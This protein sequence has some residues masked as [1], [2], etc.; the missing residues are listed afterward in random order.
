M[1]APRGVLAISAA[2]VR[3]A[4]V[5][6]CGRRRCQNSRRL[7]LSGMQRLVAAAALLRPINAAAPADSTR[8]FPSQSIP[9]VDDVV[10]A[11][12]ALG[13]PVAR[14]DE[15]FLSV[16]MDGHVWDGGDTMGF[17]KPGSKLTRVLAGALAPA[18][19]RFGGDSHSHLTYNMTESALPPLPPLPPPAYQ[20]P[21]P[22]TSMSKQQWTEINEFCAA[23]GWT[24]VFAL[25]ALLRVA[26]GSQSGRW[27]DGPTSAAA[28]LLA[29]TYA[30]QSWAPVVW[31]LAN[32][33]DLFHYAY[34]L[35]DH[36][37]FPVPPAQL[38]K[39]HASLRSLLARLAPSSAASKPVVIG[40]DVANAGPTGGGKYWAEY[41]GNQSAAGGHVD[42]ATWHHYYGSSKTATLEDTHSPLVLDKFIAQQEAMAAS[43]VQHTSGYT[44][45]IWLGETSSFYGGGAAN[46]SDR[47]G[48]GFTWL[49]KLGAAA[50]L[51][52]SVVC[53]QVRS[54]KRALWF[55]SAF[56]GL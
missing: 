25:N 17:W 13:A 54:S 4:R 19:I 28:G 3:R 9:R 6:N 36:S 45:P 7:E 30:Q 31:E 16:T 29:F 12:I 44:P 10:L 23:V 43:L 14:V 49:D 52:V 27:D 40:P 55:C 46:V 24:N 37:V 26:D 11:E 1:R 51:N 8:S 42:A 21:R 35:T 33:P 41:F 39:D 53:R 20:P 38:A 32:E 2:L 15:R 18:Y 56:V 48:A 22:T 5:E 47:F 34:N 50:R